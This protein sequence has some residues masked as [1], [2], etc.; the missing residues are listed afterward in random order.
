MRTRAVVSPSERVFFVQ[1]GLLR[2]GDLPHDSM[3]TESLSLTMGK[4]RR[5]PK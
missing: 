5:L 3:K 4:C 1:W 2:A